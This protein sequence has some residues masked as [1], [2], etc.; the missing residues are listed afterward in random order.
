[1]RYGTLPI[2]H[3]TGGLRDT[4]I[5]YNVYTGEGTGVS[6][7]YFNNDE[8][9]SAIERAVGVFGDKRFMKTLQTNAM[10]TDVDWLESARAY[11]DLYRN[12]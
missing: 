3:E 8:F 11:R 12:L 6:F 1:M 7:T 4:V 2:V 5:P 10:K 9:Y